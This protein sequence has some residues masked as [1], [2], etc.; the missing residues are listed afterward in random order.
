[1]SLLKLKTKRFK[2]EE[3][4]LNSVSVRYFS[5]FK[6]AQIKKH[7]EHKPQSL[8]EVQAYV[9]QKQK[10]NHCLLLGIYNQKGEHIGNI[11]YEPIDEHL[12]QTTMGILIGEANWRNKGVAQEVIKETALYLQQKRNINQILLGVDKDNIAAMEAYKKIGFKVD[13]QDNEHKGI[14]M[15]WQLIDEE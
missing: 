13:S 14:M 11:K 4:T 5:W 12:G 8:E 7:I 1:M 9:E 15:I 10:D 2:L 3:L 6:D